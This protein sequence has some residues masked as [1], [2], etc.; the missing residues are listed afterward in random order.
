MIIIVGERGGRNTIVAAALL[1]VDAV[2]VLLVA[3]VVA[4]FIAEMSVEA[5]LAVVAVLFVEAGFVPVVAAVLAPVC[6][7]VDSSR[8]KS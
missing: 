2:T 7:V 5:V 3:V 1:A 8:K 4:H 6:S